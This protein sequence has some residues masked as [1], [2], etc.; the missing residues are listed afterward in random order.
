MLG[1]LPR[2]LKLS[3]VDGSKSLQDALKA[4]TSRGEGHLAY[5][6]RNLRQVVVP[7]GKRIGVNAGVVRSRAPPL[8]CLWHN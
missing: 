2:P 6:E 5:P 7:P 1:A 3:F 8:H 4:S